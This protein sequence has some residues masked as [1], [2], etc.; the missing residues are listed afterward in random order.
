MANYRSASTLVGVAALVAVLLA[1]TVTYRSAGPEEKLAKKAA[2]KPT[3]QDAAT[4]RAIHKIQK[5]MMKSLHMGDEK[6]PPTREHQIR[7]R[8]LTVES[9]IGKIK[10]SSSNLF[11]KWEKERTIAKDAK[12]K[13]V[14]LNELIKQQKTKERMEEQTLENLKAKLGNQLETQ[15]KK[16]A[17]A[18]GK[19]VFTQSVARNDLDKYFA[20]LDK[21]DKMK[22]VVQH[23]KAAKVVTSAVTSAKAE[24]KADE[25]PAAEKPIMEAKAASGILAFPF[26]VRPSW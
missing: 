3:A 20:K 19:K 10:L 11:A 26:H 5:K 6:K 8:I 1:L 15:I 12:T 14:S 25:K 16:P 24:I 9:K 13:A 22:N 18:A 7:D 2:A 4:E 21:K 17:L 23:A